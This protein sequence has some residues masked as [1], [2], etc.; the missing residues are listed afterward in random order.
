MAGR[1]LTKSGIVTQE[2]VCTVNS[3]LQIIDA[4]APMICMWF[5]GAWV[6]CRTSWDFGMSLLD[7]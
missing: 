1:S 4:A 7:V 5:S 2:T 6:A 3:T